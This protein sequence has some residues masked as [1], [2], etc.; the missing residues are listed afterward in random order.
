MRQP[1]PAKHI[2]DHRKGRRTEKPDPQQRGVTGRSPACGFAR[3][4]HLH[5]R[6]A[7]RIEQCQARGRE[8]DTPAITAQELAPEFL[9]QPPNLLTEGGLRD[10]K[11]LR[12][13]AEVQGLGHRHEI[14][15]S[16]DVEHR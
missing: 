13:L 8:L 14:T 3:T 11:P 1:Q 15:E 16:P 5:E 2:R 6:P 7:T 9:L 12:R 10:A 4:R